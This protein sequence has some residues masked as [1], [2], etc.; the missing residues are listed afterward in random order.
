MRSH[1]HHRIESI[2]SAST[3]WDSDTCG[4]CVFGSLSLLYASL[5][6]TRTCCI[7]QVVSEQGAHVSPVMMPK[8]CQPLFTEQT[9]WKSYIGQLE[10]RLIHY[11]CYGNSL[12]RPISLCNCEYCIWTTVF[13]WHESVRG[14]YFVLIVLV[15]NQYSSS[16]GQLGL[17]NVSANFTFIR[18]WIYTHINKYTL[19]YIHAYRQIY[20]HT[21]IVVCTSKLWI[22]IFDFNGTVAHA[23]VWLFAYVCVV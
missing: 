22:I 18:T 16:W 3:C 6:L 13:P 9:T 14:G 8:I 15:F 2:Y 21:D 7:T 19:K 10:W 5:S 20:T 1:I 4:V 11:N 17:S 23:Y 12:H